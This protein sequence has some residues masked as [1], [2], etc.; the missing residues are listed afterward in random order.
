MHFAL[1]QIPDPVIS[2]PGS[3]VKRT[4]WQQCLM[5]V[6]KCMS[7]WQVDEWVYHHVILSLPP[8]PFLFTASSQA[9]SRRYSLGKTKRT[10]GRSLSTPPTWGRRSRLWM[11]CGGTFP[12][13]PV[14]FW[15]GL[16]SWASSGTKNRSQNTT[17]QGSPTLPH[18][19]P[20]GHLAF[21]F[22]LW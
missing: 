12:I 14:S 18:P 10:I 22:K 11:N 15:K 8:T 5:W 4:G 7:L 13:L 1:K 21:P 17:T 9:P 16:P 2:L 6:G 19:L 3:A 20:D